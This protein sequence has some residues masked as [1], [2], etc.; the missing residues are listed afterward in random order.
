MPIEDSHSRRCHRSRIW[1]SDL[2]KSGSKDLVR[3]T[4]YFHST[5]IHFIAMKYNFSSLAPRLRALKLKENVLNLKTNKNNHCHVCTNRFSCLLTWIVTAQ[6][7]MN[8]WKCIHMYSFLI[9]RRDWRLTSLKVFR[10]ICVG[11][12]CHL[13]ESFSIWQNTSISILF[14]ILNAYFGNF[15]MYEYYIHT[16]KVCLH[17]FMSMAF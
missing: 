17:N 8:T 11:S 16:G 1:T 12:G 2:W 15:N 10:Y 3:T 9:L 5:F 13:G 14:M 7:R 4:Y 6:S